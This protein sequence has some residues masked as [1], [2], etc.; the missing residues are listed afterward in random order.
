[1]PPK[2]ERKHLKDITVSAGEMLKF[3]GNIIGEPPADVTWKKETEVIETTRDK[4]LVITN[5]PY[6]TKLIIRSCKRTD[7][8][9][10]T[11]LA[12]NSVGKDMVTVNLKVLDKPGPP[13]GPLKVKKCVILLYLSNKRD[14]KLI[15]I[16]YWIKHK[17]SSIISGIFEHSF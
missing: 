7:Q 13:E 9:T 2:I 1:V 5:V 6:N 15:L 8:G 3:E 16:F 10:Y 12:K 11:V 14:K 17:S 4:S